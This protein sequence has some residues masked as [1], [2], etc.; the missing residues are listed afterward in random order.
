MYMYMYMY[1][2]IH[3]FMGSIKMGLWLRA[4]WGLWCLPEVAATLGLKIS[5]F[6]DAR[7]AS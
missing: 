7:K 6:R 4:L 5:C 3:M 1:L 2:Y